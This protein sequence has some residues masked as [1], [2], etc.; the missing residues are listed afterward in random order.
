MNVRS[1]GIHIK[2][3]HKYRA[4][5]MPETRPGKHLWVIAGMWR[6]DPRQVNEVHL[7]LENLI[8]IEGPGCY[9]CEQAYTPELAARSCEGVQN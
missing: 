5:A 3:T 4:P 9:H 6:V 8:S 7:D 1:T 2:A